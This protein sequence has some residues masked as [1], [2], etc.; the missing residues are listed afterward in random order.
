MNQVG[1]VN[2]NV[3]VGVGRD[4]SFVDCSIRFESIFE[5]QSKCRTGQGRVQN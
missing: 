5:K 4:Q 3:N 1:S 2:V